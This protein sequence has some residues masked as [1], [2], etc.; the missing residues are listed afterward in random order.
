MTDILM[1]L[2]PRF[3]DR[4]L[5]GHKR[6]EVRRR[7]PGFAAGSVIWIYATRPL[8]EVVGVFESGT[9]HQ[10]TA[11]GLWQLL[12]KDLGI[13]RSE[14]D[15]YLRDSETGYAIEVVSPRQLTAPVRLETKSS[16]PQSY[17]Y[18]RA[19]DHRLADNLR[20]AGASRR[21][22]TPGA[23]AAG[24]LAGLGR[25]M[26]RMVWQTSRWTTAPRRG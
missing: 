26:G 17:R 1:A 25:L 5:S 13:T 3:A 21:S 12:G 19:D 7:R 22:V 18:L 20:R 2:H 10:G 14:L 9:V 11:R 24:L 15:E 16:V 4:I 8:G 6:F 23:A